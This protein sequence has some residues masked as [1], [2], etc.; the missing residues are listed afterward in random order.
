MTVSPFKWWTTDNQI[1]VGNAVLEVASNIA[2]HH[3]TLQTPSLLFE[4]M[5]LT[6]LMKN[7]KIQALQALLLSSSLSPPPSSTYSAPSP[8]SPI[9]PVA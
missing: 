5:D 4:I 6:S 9:R 1:L 8:P 7:L 3:D 2:G